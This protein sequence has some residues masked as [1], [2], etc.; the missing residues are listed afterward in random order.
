[1]RLQLQPNLSTRTPP[2]VKDPTLAA[3]GIRHSAVWLFSPSGS[4]QDR[5]RPATS[6]S[7]L[8]LDR[9]RSAPTLARCSR[10]RDFGPSSPRCCVGCSGSGGC[11]LV[12]LREGSRA[13]RWHSFVR[14]LRGR[15]SDI[16]NRPCGVPQ[17]AAL[18]Q[19][20]TAQR[21]SISSAASRRF[22]TWRSW[23][24]EGPP[25]RFVRHLAWAAPLHWLV[26]L[27]RPPPRSDA[28]AQRRRLHTYRRRA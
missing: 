3:G 23:A 22:G 17:V 10:A 21:G 28:T 24:A 13:A 6:P 16:Y 1:M 2:G 15:D 4:C 25:R 20:R 8:G 18:A 12:R 14:P 26:T 27:Y 19:M 11:S 7:V 5:G 9:G